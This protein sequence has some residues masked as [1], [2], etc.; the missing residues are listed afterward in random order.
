MTPIDPPSQSHSDTSVNAALSLPRRRVIAQERWVYITLQHGAKADWQSWELAPPAVFDKLSSLRRA[1]IGLY[2][3]SRKLGATPWH[4]V[5]DSGRRITCPDSGKPTV[6]W[7]LKQRYRGMSYEDW[8]TQYR[9]LAR[10]RGGK[11]P[12]T[13]AVPRSIKPVSSFFGQPQ[14]RRK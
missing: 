13:E 4:P 6:I 8:S 12:V 7:Q 10:G 9:N 2:W 14:P 5:E 11:N 1:R 3:R